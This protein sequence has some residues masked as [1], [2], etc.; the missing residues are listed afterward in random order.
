MVRIAVAGLMAAGVTLT[1]AAQAPPAAPPSGLT[2]DVVSIRRHTQQDLGS[3][4]DERPDGGVTLMN[5]PVT[6]LIVRAYPGTAPIDMVGL[7]SWTRDRYDV[8]ATA[9]LPR[10]TPEQR[11]TM[12]RAMLADRF[13]LAVHVEN[14]PQ[15]VYYLL[16]ARVDG[17]LGPSL[18]PAN[19]TLDCE[20]LAA[21]RRAETEAALAAGK[22]APRPPV[23]GPNSPLPPCSAR[24]MG[25]RMEGELTMP[26]LATLLRGSTNRRVVDKTGLAGGY[27]V[28]LEYDR[29]AA[30]R[31]PDVTPPG[32]AGPSVFIALPE[33]LGLKLESATEDLETLVIDHIERPSDN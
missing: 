9:S 2:F 32:D 25:T 29:M 27:H 30:L 14:R 7:P 6:T 17:K 31:G 10:P 8:R 18:T 12:M 19:P 21:A 22:P 24:M 28:V 3:Q 26:I 20:A 15:Q 1:V 16:R 33:Q 13:R 11:Q 23:P 5:I 4:I